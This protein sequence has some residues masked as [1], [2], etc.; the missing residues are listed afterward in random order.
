MKNQVET[1]KPLVKMIFTLKSFDKGGV[2]IFLT[3]YK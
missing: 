2:L 3:S 1:Y